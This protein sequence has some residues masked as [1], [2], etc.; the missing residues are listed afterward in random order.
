MTTDFHTIARKIQGIK[1]LGLTPDDDDQRWLRN[2][3]VRYANSWLYMLRATR[4]DY[5]LRGFTVCRDD[6]QA[7]LGFRHNVIYLIHPI[8]PAAAVRLNEICKFFTANIDAKIVIKKVNSDLA[9]SLKSTNAFAS[10][11]RQDSKINLEDEYHRELFIDLDVLFVSRGV[12][13]PKA[14]KL[15]QKIRRFK[16]NSCLDFFVDELRDATTLGRAFRF[17]DRPKSEAYTNIIDAVLSADLRPPYIASVYQNFNSVHGIYVAEQLS[18]DAVGLYCAVTSKSS[19]GMTEWMDVTFFQKLHELGIK[20]IL[21]GGCENDGVMAYCKKL[22]VNFT[23]YSN[24]ALIFAAEESKGSGNAS[25]Q[26]DR[27]AA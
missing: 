19:P 12:L 7:G 11:C 10:A 9:T 13:N 22:L 15:R 6:F 21:L 20:K 18:D 14:A 27:L 26:T 25:W 17:L 4:S 2:G 1:P 24:E 8:G 23:S 5:G 3:P 16:A